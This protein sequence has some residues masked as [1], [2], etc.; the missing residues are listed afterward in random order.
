[1]IYR[2]RFSPQVRRAVNAPVAVSLQH[3]LT[4]SGRHIAHLLLAFLVGLKISSSLLCI[5]PTLRTSGVA[6]RSTIREVRQDIVDRCGADTVLQ[7]PAAY[8][9]IVLTD[10][11]SQRPDLHRFLVSQDTPHQTIHPVLGWPHSF[12]L[13]LH[14]PSNP[15][16]E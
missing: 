16:I 7:G 6:G 4:L 12:L 11:C 14:V 5:R 3:L 9:D 1:M 2:Q 10:P 8:V 15:L 13:P